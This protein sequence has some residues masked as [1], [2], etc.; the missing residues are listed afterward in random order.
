M[1]AVITI[2]EKPVGVALSGPWTVSVMVP[3]PGLESVMGLPGLKVVDESLRSEELGRA[4]LASWAWGKIRAQE[5]LPPD[6]G[7]QEEARTARAFTQ[8]LSAGV[9]GAENS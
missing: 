9:R 8:L 2:D 1:G 3:A 6:R 4:A 5:L 7:T